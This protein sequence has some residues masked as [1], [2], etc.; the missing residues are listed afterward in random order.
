MMKWLGCLGVVVVVA[1]VGGRHAHRHLQQPR[2]PRAGG[3]RPV[4]ARSRT[5]TS[6]APTSSRTWCRPSRAR[7]TSRSRPSSRWSRPGPAW[8]RST[9]GNLPNDPAAFA[10]FQQAQDALSSAL[11]R[12]MVVV[13]RY[14]DLKAN[15]NFRDLQ[16]QLEGTENRIA[17][18]RMRYNEKAQGYNT[19]RLRFPAV[20]FARLLGLRREGLLQGGGRRRAG[21]DRGLQ[22]RR[23]ARSGGGH[24]RGRA[25]ASLR[26]RPERARLAVCSW[27]GAARV[28][29]GGRCRRRPRPTSTTTRASSPRPTA[30]RLDDEAARAST[31]QTSTQVVVAVFPELPSPSLEDFTD[32]HRRGLAGRPQGARQR[33]RPLRLRR[34]PQACASRSATASRAPCPTRSPRASSTSRWCPAS[35]RATGR[36]GSRPASTPS[37]PRRAA[38]TRPRPQKRR[39]TSRRRPRHRRRLRPALPPPRRAP[40]R[41][42]RRPDLRPTRGRRRGQ[43]PLG[44]GVHWGGGGLVGGGGGGWSAAA[45]AS[46]AAA[47]RSGAAGPR[48]AG[49]GSG[50]EGPTRS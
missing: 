48:A 43:Q 19:A 13:E 15:Q 31:R 32:P 14:P 38:S 28:R 42:A 30:R 10:R 8:A 12:L 6:A 39:G 35:A 47:A 16:V 37:W 17:V 2:R 49:E 27:P 50:D 41:G 11:S 3:G 24:A 9:S 34:G 29:G 33:G 25:T 23:H 45:A 22:L 44:R 46:R 4:G 36:A 26:A 21:A 5:S 1:L 7:P 18:E 40:A 20:L